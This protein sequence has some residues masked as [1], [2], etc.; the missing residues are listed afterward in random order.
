[1]RDVP[2]MDAPSQVGRPA[3]HEHAAPQS[4]PLL[5][6]VPRPEAV[7]LLERPHEGLSP[8]VPQAAPQGPVSMPPAGDTARAESPASVWTAVDPT[9]SGLSGAAMPGAWS[10]AASRPVPLQQAPLGRE[11]RT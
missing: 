9:A 3:H 8:G 5:H 10:A 6:E 11:P 2:R 4:A 7:P 1:M